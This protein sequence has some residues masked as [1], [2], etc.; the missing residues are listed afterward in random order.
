MMH[1]MSDP[2]MSDLQPFNSFRKL[3]LVPGARDGGG[4]EGEGMR[5]Y[6]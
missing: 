6:P 3:V 4:V 1:I 2:L 5:S